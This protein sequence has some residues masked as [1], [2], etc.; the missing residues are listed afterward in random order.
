MDWKVPGVTYEA[1]YS[2]CSC[3]WFCTRPDEEA[4]HAAGA[5]HAA[6][7][8]AHGVSVSLPAAP[9]PA[10]SALGRKPGEIQTR[11]YR[12]GSK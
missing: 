9:I 3:G 11:V 7:H 1:W 12:A 2:W 10:R 4:T 6:G 5:V 8:Q